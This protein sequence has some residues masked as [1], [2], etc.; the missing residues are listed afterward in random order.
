MLDLTNFDRGIFADCHSDVAA[1][2][3]HVALR[4]GTIGM[5]STGPRQNKWR[6]GRH[7]GYFARW[8]EL[9]KQY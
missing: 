2:S 1:Q 5:H 8:E 6:H 4:D 9:L 3:A 7:A